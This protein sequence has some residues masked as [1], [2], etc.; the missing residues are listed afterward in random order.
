MVAAILQ[1]NY[2][3][4]NF[5]ELT[6]LFNKKYDIIEQNI[7]FITPDAIY[8]GSKVTQNTINKKI[9]K[10]C[11]TKWK[12]FYKN[13]KDKH[14]KLYFMTGNLDLTEGFEYIGF[15]S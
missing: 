10:E 3:D 9:V 15:Y 6:S 14:I 1:E 7:D 4:T 12:D 2:T 11:P 13:C 8:F 5:R